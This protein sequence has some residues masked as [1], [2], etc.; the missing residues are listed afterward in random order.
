[1]L[2]HVQK[3]DAV[4]REF[5]QLLVVLARR[6]IE[7]A[8][9][10]FALVGPF[11]L[12]LGEVIEPVVGEQHVLVPADVF[13]QIPAPDAEFRHARAE[14]RLHAFVH[15]LVELRRLL[16]RVER[17]LAGVGVVAGEAV[18]EDEPERRERRRAR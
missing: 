2:E 12:Q 5:A 10:Q 7:L 15:P 6:H 9:P 4:R 8:D 18:F 1:M 16:H 11:A 14:P 17:D 3:D 13:A